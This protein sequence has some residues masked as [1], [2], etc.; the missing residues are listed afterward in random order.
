MIMHLDD[1][2]VL[3]RDVTTAFRLTG[4]APLASRVSGN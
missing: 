1:V 3:V 2:I 4:E